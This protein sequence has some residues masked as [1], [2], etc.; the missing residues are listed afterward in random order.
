MTLEVTGEALEV[1]GEAVGVRVVVEVS[2][3]FHRGYGGAL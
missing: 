2:N 1:T 3:V